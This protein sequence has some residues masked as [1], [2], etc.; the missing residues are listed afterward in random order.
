VTRRG[1]GEFHHPKIR[2]W[3]GGE[4]GERKGGEK[5]NAK[6]RRKKGCTFALYGDKKKEE[7]REKRKGKEFRA[8]GKKA[9]AFF[10]AGGGKGKS[11]PM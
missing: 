7:E 11:S 2:Q 8:R 10:I 1:K 9:A 5:P 4:G 3:G 6:T